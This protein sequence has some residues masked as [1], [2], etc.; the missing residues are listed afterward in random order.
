LGVQQLHASFLNVSVSKKEKLTKSAAGSSE[1]ATACNILKI[2]IH[3]LREKLTAQ[4][5]FVYMIQRIQNPRLFH[6]LKYI[7]G[8]QKFDV[9]VV[10][11]VNC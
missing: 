10:G 8:L 2:E 7:S 9:I 11:V 1:R 6:F 4:Q 5:N 3:M